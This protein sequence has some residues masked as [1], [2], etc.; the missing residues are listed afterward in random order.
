MRRLYSLLIYATMILAVVTVWA[1]GYELQAQSE[2]TRAQNIAAVP[3]FN[4]ELARLERAEAAEA[5]P[6]AAAPAT[7]PAP[8]APGRQDANSTSADLTPNPDP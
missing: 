2:L 1:M 3:Q 5:H 8:P 6:A 7:R 4:E